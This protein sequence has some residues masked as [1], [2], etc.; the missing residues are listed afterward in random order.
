MIPH[1]MI[2]VNSL[3]LAGTGKVNSKLLPSPQP[4]D[5]L[6]RASSPQQHQQEHDH[7][8]DDNKKPDAAVPEDILPLARDIA[9]IFTEVLGR[10]C[11]VQDDFFFSGGHSILAARAVQMLRSRLGGEGLAVP[12]TALLAHPTPAALAARLA[13]M[14]RWK[15]QADDLPASLVLLRPSTAPAASS[16][17]GETGQ[18]EGHEEKPGMTIDVVVMHPIG[19]GLM[20]MAGLVDALGA[21]LRGG[22]RIVG[23]PWSSSSGGGSSSSGRKS[24]S[25]SNSSRSRSRNR[26]ELATTGKDEEG[27]SSSFPL[28]VEALAARYANILADFISARRRSSRGSKHPLYLLGWSFGGTLAYETGKHVQSMLMEQ[29]EEASFQVIL[30]DAPTLDAALREIDPCA[31]VAENYAEHIIEYVAERTRSKKANA[32]SSSL[33][34]FCREQPRETKNRSTAPN[35]TQSHQIQSLTRLLRDSGVDEYTDLAAL[36]PLVRKCYDNTRGIPSWIT[37]SDLVESV[38]GLQGNLQALC[39]SSY[40]KQRAGAGQREKKN[41]ASTVTM[42]DDDRRRLKVVQV[43]ASHGL[44]ARLPNADLGWEAELR[45]QRGRVEWTKHAVDAGHDDVLVSAVD[46]VAEH[47]AGK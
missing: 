30:L 41:E 18:G 6:S 8:D 9:A 43:Q 32:L 36:P 17:E 39:G 44:G 27:A 24:S 21:R 20:P 26:R 15:D 33:S 4:S 31:L 3:P 12:F 42:R 25:S 35:Q 40:R 13:D 16:Q 38:R 1:Y 45:L 29:E 22:A 14:R 7:P 19:G 2:S 34:S 10:C 5:L 37:D 28:T 46:L 23:L 47:I 11:S